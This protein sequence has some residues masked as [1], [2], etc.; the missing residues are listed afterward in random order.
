MLEWLLAR[1]EE[2]STYAGFASLVLSFTFLPSADI[3]EASKLIALAGTIIP[4]ILAMAYPETKAK[5]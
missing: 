4:S 5:L 1:L 3:T 2:P